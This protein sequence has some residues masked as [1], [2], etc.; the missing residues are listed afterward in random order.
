MA[1]EYKLRLKYMVKNLFMIQ[2]VIFKDYPTPLL[3]P[4]SSIQERDIEDEIIVEH[5]E[6]SDVVP[7][8]AA[9][10]SYQPV[11]GHKMKVQLIR[12][13][14]EL[15][16]AL[17]LDANGMGKLDGRSRIWVEQ[18]RG[19]SLEAQF[20]L[21][22][23][24]AKLNHKPILI[25][26]CK[27][28]IRHVVSNKIDG[29]RNK[30]EDAFRRRKA[31]G[32]MQIQS[33]VV[34]K[35]QILC[36]RMQPYLAAKKSSVVGFDDDTQVLMTELLSDEKCRCI[37]WIVGVGGTDQFVAEIGK[38]TA[39]K[40]TVEEENVPTDYVLIT[41]AHSKYLIV[42]DGLK[43]T[44]KVYLDTLNRVI[45]DMLT[46]SRVLFTTRNATVAQ[47]AAGRIILHPLQLLDDET[48]WLLFT[49]HLKV[50]KSE[51]ELIKVGKEIV[52]KCGGLPSQIL[53]ISDLLSHK[54]VTHEEW[55]SVLGGQQ[56]NE[57]Q[58][59]CWSETL[60]TINTN[61]P[62]YLRRC[63]FY[64]VLFPAEFG[65]PVRRLVV[66]W[67]AESLIH[68]AED[69]KV[70][71]ELVVER[72]LTELIDRN[73]VQVS[74]R[75]R[76]EQGDPSKTFDIPQNVKIQIV[77][78]L[79]SK[80]YSDPKLESSSNVS[81]QFPSANDHLQVHQKFPVA[82]NIK[83]VR[84]IVDSK[85][86]NQSASLHSPVSILQDSDEGSISEHAPTA[87][88]FTT[89]E[90][91]RLHIPLKTD[92]YVVSDFEGEPSSIIAC[93]LSLLKDSS[94]M[95]KIDGDVKE[96]GITSK[97]TDSL[98]DSLDSDS[99]HSTGSVS[100]EESRSSRATEDHSKEV[101]LGYAKITWEG[102]IFC[103]GKSKSFFAKTLDERF[104]VK[105]IK[106]T[107]LEA[108]LGFSSLYFKHMR[109]SFES[110]SQTCLATVLGIY[111]VTRRHI[112]SGK[113]VKQHDLMVK[114]NLTYNRNIVCQYDLKGALFERYTSD[115]T[116]AEEFLLDQNFVEDMNSS[117]LYVSHISPY[118]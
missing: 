25:Y 75:K 11:M 4:I 41:L 111:Q 94:E 112:K 50:P 6:S 118:Q 97:S 60:D 106:K 20:V 83:P 104:I 51:T 79:G 80:R 5:D 116:G 9:S 12:G 64:F 113:E 72:Y 68:Q 2:V 87:N 107:E 35:I 31:Y 74:K 3:T 15:T 19:I 93:A 98:H 59:Q 61:L 45:P 33:R 100:S 96:I 55:L 65:I 37:T 63:L 10:S 49:R 78:G 85:V 101:H 30:M 69:D 7:A 99:A 21:N 115:A 26:I 38:E 22:K 32:L 57:N 77:D 34:S 13:E 70:P 58:I 108:F 27:Y 23:Y 8:A 47:H 86:L 102:K 71:P 39:K 73:M 88:Q 67:V 29:I 84:P 44:S 105:E 54:D 114:K 40:I 66:L 18:L 109:E 91:P 76:N 82:I 36:A 48:S 53:K 43:E 103:G 52:M 62:Y 28:W 14:K 92:N 17:L 1:H 42:V 56:L 24:N 110:G 16:D 95:S 117:P 46:G 90:G 89:E 81:T